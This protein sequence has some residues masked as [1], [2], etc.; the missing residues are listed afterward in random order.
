MANPEHL[1]ILMQGVEVWNKWREDHPEEFLD[2]RGAKLGASKFFPTKFVGTDFIGEDILRT[3]LSGALLSG[4]DLC[5]ADLS[6]AN[7]RGAY[8]NKANLSD[9]NLRGASLRGAHLCDADIRGADLKGADL[10]EADL[11]DSDLN[12]AD[13][14]NATLKGADLTGVNFTLVDLSEAHLGDADLSGVCIRT[15]ILRKT[16]L[17]GCLMS[18]NVIADVDL[19]ECLGLDLVRHW[20]PAHIG[21]DTLYRSKGKIPEVFLRG[22]GV[23]DKLIEYLPSLINA[24]EAIQFYSCFISYSTKDEEFARRLHERMQREH[25]R[26][27]FAPEDMK[28]GEKLHE[29][30]ERAIQLHDR[31]LVVLSE[32]SLKSEWVQE[33]IQKARMTEKRE[34]RRKLFPIRLVDFEVIEKWKCPYGGVAK[35]MADELREYFIPDFSNWKDHDSFEKA[36]AKLLKDLRAAK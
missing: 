1:K 10:D 33:E 32:D 8:F 23:P 2:L 7:L 34:N 21:I 26:V 14:S 15:S 29:Q 4:A 27:W 12:S 13:L 31:L 3:D 11:T 28:G 19:S 5:D 16:N 17:S 9:A 18:G 6:G 36:F 25:L 35:D 20:A 30:I 24:Q 22:C